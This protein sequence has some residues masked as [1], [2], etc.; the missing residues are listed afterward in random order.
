MRSM[1]LYAAVAASFLAGGAATMLITGAG[2]QPAPT[3]PGLDAGMPGGPP[4]M[5][6]GM[7]PG[8]W[9]RGGGMWRTFALLYHPDDR[10]LTA[11]E[12]QKIAE[13]FLLWNGNRTWKVTEVAEAP[14]NRIGFAFATADGGVIAR[15]T[16]D[17]KTGR[18]SRSG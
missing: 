3:V 16:M 7:G 18:L 10:Q 9:H 4:P 11:A 14:D 15:F 6:P 5:A 8:R 1:T 2:A 17:R 13:A 12:V